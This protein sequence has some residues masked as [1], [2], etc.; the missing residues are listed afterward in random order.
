MENLHHPKIALSR[1]SGSPKYA[2]YEQWLR[3][4]GAAG[5]VIDLWSL[6]ASERGVVL[7]TCDG[8]VLTG[9]PDIEPSRYGQGDRLEECSVDL[10]RDEAEF[11]LFEQAQEHKM[12]V[13]AI[14]RGL[15][16][17]NVALGGSLIVDIPADIPTDIEHRS[18]NHVESV[19]P[20]KVEPGSLIAKICRAAVGT[21]NSS[22]H[23]AAEHLPEHLRCAAVSPDGIIEA[24]EWS[25]PSGKGFM[26][27]VQWHP[28]RMDYNSP[29]S[30]PIARHFLF[31]AESYALLRAKRSVVS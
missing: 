22:H 2:F 21:I 18:I 4:A 17:I 20:V 8:I 24:F 31:E 3:A 1:A 25:E 15:Q 14:C 13:L 9:G 23:Q 16:L 11:A 30:L 19:H 28:E 26:L 29:F 5:E 27:G 10:E 6:P 12:P 7:A